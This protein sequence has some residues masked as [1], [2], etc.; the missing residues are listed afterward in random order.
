MGW[1][2][3]EEAPTAGVQLQGCH[4]TVILCIL[5]EQGAFSFF[6][7]VKVPKHRVLLFNII[8]HASI[9][10]QLYTWE[11]KSAAWCMSNGGIYQNKCGLDQPSAVE[12]T[13]KGAIHSI[14]HTLADLKAS[15]LQHSC[16]MVMCVYSFI[17]DEHCALWHL[18]C[19]VIFEGNC[20]CT[21]QELCVFLCV[22][23]NVLS[24]QWRI[25]RVELHIKRKLPVVTWI[26]NKERHFKWKY[27]RM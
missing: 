22:P 9:L 6:G 17:N 5:L 21:V 8:I 7:R 1:T 23:R 3:D 27:A 16:A 26:K 10:H 13:L 18:S 24:Q 11:D 4:E 14:R 20:C 15:S 12:H 2:P 25:G 19:C